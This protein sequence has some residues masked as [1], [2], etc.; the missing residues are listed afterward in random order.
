MPITNQNSGGTASMGIHNP[1]S[2]RGETRGTAGA[3][4]GYP[5]AL[6]GA[7]RRPVA[8]RAAG[9]D[10][11]TCALLGDGLQLAH[12]RGQAKRAAAVR[13]I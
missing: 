5:L 11:G 13:G 9:D 2:P 4:R 1:R 10:P 6:Q 12:V 8:G 7:R 3:H